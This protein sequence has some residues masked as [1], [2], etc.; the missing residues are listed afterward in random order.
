MS[1]PLAIRPFVRADQAA[2]L[3]IF[4][5]N[6]PRYF[7]PS[8]RPEFVRFV[9]TAQDGSV[10]GCGGYSVDSNTGFAN[11]TW[12]MVQRSWQGRGIGEML[13]LARIAAIE[14]SPTVAVIRATT[15]Q[16]VRGFFER[17][18]FKLV[19]ID[20]DGLAQGLDRVEME[21]P[22]SRSTA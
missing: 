2:C 15:S 16:H 8:E 20:P 9:A 13:L 1:A 5:G 4:D 17:H 22:L 6:T 21:R 10:I 18:G 3:A 12:G 19:R 11:L 7:A 14:A